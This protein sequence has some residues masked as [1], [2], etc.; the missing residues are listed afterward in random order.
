MTRK[1]D[2]LVWEAVKDE[3]VDEALQA[4]M[5]ATFQRSKVAALA[6]LPRTWQSSYRLPTPYGVLDVWAYFRGCWKVKRDSHPLIRGDGPHP[7]LFTSVAGAKAAGLIHLREGFGNQALLN[8]TLRWSTSM[9][10]AKRA[11]FKKG[12][13][14]ADLP[15][16]HEWGRK[17]LDR[18][19][20]KSASSGAAADENLLIDIRHV[21][22][23]WR[24]PPPPWT[25][26][27]QGL[28]CLDTPYGAL[29]VRRMVGWAVERNDL[30]LV[31]W[32]TDRRVIYDKLEDA[33]TS[34]LVH[35]ADEG[36]N[37]RYP[38]GTRWGEPVGSKTAADQ[39][40]SAA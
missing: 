9:S 21:A 13:F 39:M 35:M 40:L 3:L 32:C 10:T 6:W 22:Q 37:I 33:K 7:A 30:P 26:V 4:Q 2:R 14:A 24:L 18:L 36:T 19:L 38:D 29:S 28:Y 5:A 8:N 17:Q 27:A 34:A 20:S 12:D 23:W 15:D 1:L 31:W 25:R 11:D 16:D